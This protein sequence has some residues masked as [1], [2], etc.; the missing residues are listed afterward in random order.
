LGSSARRLIEPVVGSTVAPEK[1]SV[2]SW[3]YLLPS[4][5]VTLTV[6]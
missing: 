1:S 4:G 2:P 3:S 6:V 5:S